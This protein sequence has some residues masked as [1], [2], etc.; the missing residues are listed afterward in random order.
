MDGTLLDSTAALEGAWN[1][2]KERYPDIDI[3]DIMSC[4][5]S[6]MLAPMTFT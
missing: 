1:I 3:P 4:E 5:Y 2:F 6:S